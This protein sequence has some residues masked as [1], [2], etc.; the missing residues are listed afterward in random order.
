MAY[1]YVGRMGSLRFSP[2]FQDRSREDDLAVL[3]SSD[4]YARALMDRQHQNRMSKLVD[5]EQYG[6]L[7]RTEPPPYG[8]GGPAPPVGRPL[9]SHYA[10]NVP[11]DPYQREWH[12]RRD[13]HGTQAEEAR[14]IAFD[15][16]PGL[17]L[18]DIQVQD[19]RNDP[20]VPERIYLRGGKAEFYGVGEIGPP[21][22]RRDESERA[23]SGPYA[24]S[25]PPKI[26]IYDGVDTTNESLPQVIVG[27]MLHH[28]GQEEYAE[29]EEDGVLAW[30]PTGA[31]VE[32]RGIAPRFQG[33]LEKLVETQTASQRERDY[34]HYLREKEAG[35]DRS[36]DDWW[37]GSSRDAFV[38]GYLAP[39]NRD[40][41]RR[42]D[43]YTKEQ[44]KILE[45][46][47]RLL[48]GR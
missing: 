11:L 14:Q 26:E 39:D 15:R 4:A 41:R 22:M 13:R 8:R 29:T 19:R 47:K 12:S 17:R 32:K 16:Y 37:R 21:D 38:R 45:E 28:L 40:E 36:Y 1:P 10:K 7:G 20:T 2:A 5:L 34:Q 24:G 35:E 42:F 31:Y 18:F 23:T 25:F 3:P 6:P 43:D 44:R 48:Q 46:M 27:D 33:L 30:K 9:P